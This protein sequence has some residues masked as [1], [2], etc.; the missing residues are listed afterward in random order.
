M[1]TTKQ[2]KIQIDSND[3]QTWTFIKIP[4]N[5]NQNDENNNDNEFSMCFYP[6]M[7]I[8]SSCV[9]DLSQIQTT[10]H[11][12]QNENKNK[13]HFSKRGTAT[14][15]WAESIAV[16]IILLIIAVILAGFTLAALWF[17]RSNAL[18]CSGLEQF[19]FP[20]AHF[21]ATQLE[22][23]SYLGVSSPAASTILYSL[24]ISTYGK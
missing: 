12:Q 22:Q 10:N 4:N 7:P 11:Q 20:K 2:T 19:T 24:L 1:T 3:F 13:E 21:F 6:S 9:L 17:Q 15:T 23:P 14:E 8:E 16:K 18:K 5:F